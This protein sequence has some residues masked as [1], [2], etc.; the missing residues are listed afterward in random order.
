MGKRNRNRQRRKGERKPGWMSQRDFEIL[1][2]LDDPTMV[3][4]R[5]S[6]SFGPGG[7]DF[8]EIKFKLPTL[9]EARNAH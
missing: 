4:D 1:K 3:I 2:K 5:D 8:S 6:V 7:I 9:W